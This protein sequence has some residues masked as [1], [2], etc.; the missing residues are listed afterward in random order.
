MIDPPVR[1]KTAL[2]EQNMERRLVKAKVKSQYLEE[3]STSGASKHN[4]C[5]HSARSI[6]DYKHI[7]SNHSN[8]FGREMNYKSLRNR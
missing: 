4:S 7:L 3:K 2:E 1:Q 5:H 8:F 6:F